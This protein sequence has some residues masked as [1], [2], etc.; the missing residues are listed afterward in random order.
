MTPWME[1]QPV[2]RI[3]P[4]HR[5]A[6][7][8]NKRTQTSMPQMGFESMIPVFEQVKTVHALDCVATV[9]DISSDIVSIYQTASNKLHTPP[10]S[11]Q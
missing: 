8:Q 3:L 11:E 1:D 4:A 9:I 2:T 7:T 6:Q 5:T 10:M